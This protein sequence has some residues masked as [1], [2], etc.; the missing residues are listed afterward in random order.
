M[1]RAR[2]RDQRRE[3]GASSDS[4]AARVCIENPAGEED[5]TR[6]QR[7]SMEKPTGS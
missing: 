3:A 7:I 5:S 4:L 6:V 2:D 1:L